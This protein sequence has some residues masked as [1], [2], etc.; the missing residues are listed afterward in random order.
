MSPNSEPWVY[1]EESY[2]TMRHLSSDFI[3]NYLISAGASALNSPGC[4]QL[5]KRGSQLFELIEGDFFAILGLPLIP[6][7]RALRANEIVP[8]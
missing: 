4:Y 8:L 1:N 3:K 5:E 2:L 7:M 6:T